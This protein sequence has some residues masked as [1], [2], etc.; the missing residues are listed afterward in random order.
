MTGSKYN[1]H[2]GPLFTQH[3]ILTF[4]QLIK[5][6]KLIFMHSIYYGYAPKS[7]ANTWKK[8]ENRPGE[9]NI[10]LRNDN[11]FTIPAPRIEFFKRMPMYSLPVEWNKSETLMFY[12]NV[13]TFKSILRETLL[14]EIPHSE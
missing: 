5:Q 8:N 10:S 4:N 12:N 11:L 3:K 9:L 14:Q 2:T 1:E 6:G 13:F 7:F